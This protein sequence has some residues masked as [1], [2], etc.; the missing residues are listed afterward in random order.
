MSLVPDKPGLL[1]CFDKSS[2]DPDSQSQYG[3]REISLEYDCSHKSYTVS[4]HLGLELNFV[5]GKDN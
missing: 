2:I 5:V 1:Y 4:D 3:C